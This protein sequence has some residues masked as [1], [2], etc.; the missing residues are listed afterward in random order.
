MIWILL[1]AVGFANGQEPP[2]ETTRPDIA[3]LAPSGKVSPRSLY[4]GEPRPKIQANNGYVRPDSKTRFRRY[5]NSMFGPMSLGKSALSAGYGTWRNSPEEWGDHW[6]GFGKRFASSL[7]K[8]I[9]K[10]TTMYGLDE[11]LKYDSSFYRSEK[12]DF[13]SRLKNALLAPVTARNERGKRV[14]GIP[15]IV[16]TYTSSIVA[17]ETWYPDRYDYKDGLKNGTISLGMNAAFN[18]VKEFIWKK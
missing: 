6:D 3:N 12:K 1:I 10:K 4:D 7:G 8:G 13:G 11:V 18:V 5:V 2:A 14:I 15:R 16:G 17:A 9:V